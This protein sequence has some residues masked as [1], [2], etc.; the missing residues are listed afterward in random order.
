M[1]CG[2]GETPC[3]RA[4][5]R[6]RCSDLPGPCSL[7]YHPRMSY[8]RTLISLVAIAIPMLEAPPAEAT[9]Q[10]TLERLFADPPLVGNLPRAIQ[11]SHDGQR[12][13]YL[14]TRYGATAEQEFWVM[15]VATG[16]AHQVFSLSD[17]L[18][19]KTLHTRSV[20]AALTQHPNRIK[21]ATFR[22]VPGDQAILF[23]LEGDLFLFDL[24]KARPRALTD[25]RAAEQATRF[26]PDHR[27]LSYVRDGNLY[28]LDMA[29][30]QE[31]QLTRS[32]RSTGPVRNG[33]PDYIAREEL[34]RYSGYWWSPDG[35]F[36]A[37]METD[38]S[39][40]D[41]TPRVTLGP[42]GY[43]VIPEAF[44]RAGEQNVRGRLGIMT[45][46][47]QRVRWARL[48]EHGYL[49]ELRWLPDSKGMIVVHQARHQ[50]MLEVL[51]L[52]RRGKVKKILI[53]ETSPTW[54]PAHH[55]LDVSPDGTRLLWASEQD[56]PRAIFLYDMEGNRLGA[57][58]PGLGDIDEIAGV[59][60]RNN[61][62]F[63]H[64]W[65]DSPVEKHL[66]VTDLDP[67]T[68][69]LPRRV[70]R[71]EY[72]HRAVISPD[73]TTFV[74][75]ETH[76]VRLPSVA[77]RAIDNRLLYW[78]DENRLTADHPYAP[79][80]GAHAAPSFGTL[81]A[82]DGTTLHYRLIRPDGDGPFPVIVHVYGGP[83]GQIVR[84]SWMPLW[85]QVAV[86]RGYAVFSL[87]NRGTARRGHDFERGLFGQLGKVEVADQIT[88]LDWLRR[89]PFVDPNRIGVYG[90]SYG[91]YMALKLGLA[92]PDRIAAVVAG[93]PVTDWRLYD[94][95]YTERY[96]GLPDANPEAYAASDVFPE[97]ASLKPA[98][99]LIHG[100]ADDNVTFENSARVMA[101]LQENAIP[102]ETM[103]Y[104]GGG[105]NIQGAGP[106][107]HLHE[108][109]FR[110]WERNLK[111]S[112]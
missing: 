10:L 54:V 108:T 19:D 106:E 35:R 76:P 110:F 47:G 41:V 61:R 56:G 88:G 7:H 55:D 71:D 27:H 24:E 69:D 9:T 49:V 59:D 26:A 81:A 31:W 105:H 104:P 16:Q 98:L 107:R 33:L 78:I 73:A 100:L 97:I 102:F 32:G 34:K 77:L 103:V 82:E 44:P 43:T 28:L 50:K 40:L 46:D 39:G 74:D 6:C 92:A 21:L 91:G 52:D 38:E 12:L 30:R 20:A 65:L 83:K 86:A 51:H 87:D 112:D 68:T 11:F 64:G 58:T 14:K 66:F 75:V 109:I 42:N 93:A 13:G 85:Y 111:G 72:W 4:R 36:I 95:H 23:T 90:W 3:A 70:T 94:T 17:L 60:W 99:L 5:S 18:Q 84:K 22:W 25:T 48:P 96:L 67:A 45:L 53:R 62:L 29:T 2:P 15:E 101:V 89:Q 8:L 57:L 1:S 63:V 79:F 80:A 37:F